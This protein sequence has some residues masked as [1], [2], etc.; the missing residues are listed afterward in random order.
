MNTIDREAAAQ[1]DPSTNEQQT[2][3]LY[4]TLMSTATQHGDHDAGECTPECYTSPGVIIKKGE[5]RLAT[6]DV[7]WMVT[8]KQTPDGHV[9]INIDMACEGDDRAN[10]LAR[11]ISLIKRGETRL[12]TG[13][14][15]WRV[16]AK[17]TPDGHVSNNIDMTCEGDARANMLARVISLTT[18]DIKNALMGR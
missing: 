5:T 6:G 9:S 8:A 18:E 2:R 11:V 16:T 4:A 12:A 7:S 3:D 17:Q 10:M 15:S 14:V 1:A 13:G